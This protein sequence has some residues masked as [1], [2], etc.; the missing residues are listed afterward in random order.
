MITSEQ[1]P[2]V[3]DH[4]VLGEDGKKIVDGGGHLSEDEEHRPY[5]YWW[6]PRGRPTPRVRRN[7]AAAGMRGGSDDDAMTRSMSALT[8]V[9]SAVRRP[10]VESEA[11]PVE[12]VRKERIESAGETGEDR[13]G[14][15]P[16]D[17]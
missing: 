11:V 7:R 8:W 14:M 5:D 16:G 9:S 4:P 12:G 3:P 1:I 6:V 10:V 2:A 13:G 17:R 15:G